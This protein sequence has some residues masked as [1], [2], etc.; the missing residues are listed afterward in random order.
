M[1]APAWL[2]LSRRLLLLLL[3]RFL[4]LQFVLLLA[5]AVVLLL[6]EGKLLLLLLQHLL[7]LVFVVVMYEVSFTP[8][9]GCRRSGRRVHRHLQRCVVHKMTQSELIS[10]MI[11]SS[12]H[13]RDARSPCDVH[14]PCP[15]TGSVPSSSTSR[16]KEGSLSGSRAYWPV[17]TGSRTFCSSWPRR[18][19]PRP[20]WKGESSCPRCRHRRDCHCCRCRRRQQHC[21]R[22]PRDPEKMKPVNAIL[23]V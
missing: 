12:L 17:S 4:S 20:R 1:F 21:Q 23:Y 15:L 13:L 3:L 18:P 5:V 7:L 22:E 6:L 8:C 10:I 9:S 19:D 16:R 2:V 14:Q 11:K